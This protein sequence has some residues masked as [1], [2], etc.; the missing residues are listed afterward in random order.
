MKVTFIS[1][2]I[3]HHQ[4]P[5]ANE[6]YSYL[7]DEYHF[8]QTEPME[9]DRVQMGWG[10]EVKNIPYL[11]KYYEEKDVCD[12]LL[13]NSD[14]V[15]VGGISDE[16]CVIPR[17]EKGLFTIRY[18]ER[19]YKEGQWKRFSPRGLKQKYHDFIRFRKGQ[20]YL[21]CAGGYVADDYDLI[22]AFPDK[23]LR[24]GYFPSNY[25][26]NLEELFQKKRKNDV[27]LILWTGRMLDW[28]HPEYAMYMA[29]KLREKGYSFRLKFIGDGEM[30]ET[31]LKMK[32]EFSL[33]EVEFEAFMPPSEVRSVME[34]ADIYLVTSDRKEGWGAVVN[35]AMN[36]GC[37]VVASH[38]IGAAPYLIQHGENGLVFRSDD[39]ESLTEEVEMILNNTS[40]LRELG[41]TAY[42]TIDKMWNAKIAAERLLKFCENV[43]INLYDDG[44]C[45]KEKP[46]REKKMYRKLTKVRK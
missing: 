2:Y 6:L 24:W 20:Y 45:S 7:G 33:Q 11:L 29:K 43:D 25:Q 16:S 8:I 9:E 40:Y 14:V 44:P 3:N 21:F 41:E 35:E 1:N 27:P 26:Y 39:V 15:I 36:S 38:M 5:L 28:K 42:E 22:K 4:I 19:I 31:L 10:A 34:S 32:Q 30:K 17:L 37:A 23:M 12:Q 13:M 18:S 46:V